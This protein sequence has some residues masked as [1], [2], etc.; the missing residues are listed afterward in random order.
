MKLIK[1]SKFEDCLNP[2]QLWENVWCDFDKNDEEKIKL[3]A[4]Y[5]H[6]SIEE[7]VMEFEIKNENAY[8]EG[9]LEGRRRERE[10]ILNL[11]KK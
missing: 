2:T 9:I 10:A 7:M 11:I 3:I 8:S 5:Y 6:E 4:R 1:F